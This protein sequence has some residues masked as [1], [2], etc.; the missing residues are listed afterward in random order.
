M[1]IPNSC[2]ECRFSEPAYSGNRCD[3]LYGHTYSKILSE[4]IENCP[5]KSVG[6]AFSKMC[7]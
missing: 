5:L 2:Y 1:D 4:R 3:N 6:F 7:W